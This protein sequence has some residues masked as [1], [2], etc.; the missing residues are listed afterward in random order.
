[1]YIK[2]ILIVIYTLRIDHIGCFGYTKNT[3]AFIDKLAGESAVFLN[4]TATGVPTQPSFLN[5]MIGKREIKTAVVSHSPHKTIDE[6]P[7]LQQLLTRKGYVTGAVSTLY[8]IR[9][10][11]SGG[12]AL[13]AVRD[14][15]AARI[16]KS[17]GTTT[18]RSTAPTSSTPIR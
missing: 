15:L 18:E 3:S 16:D 8:I 6:V 12:Y 5:M 17:W 7:L 14:A 9:S 4:D 2:F 13:A 11:S 1:M 10:T